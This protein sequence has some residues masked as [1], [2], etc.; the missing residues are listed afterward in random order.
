MSDR[1]PADLKAELERHLERWISRLG[2]RA[3]TEVIEIV[4]RRHRRPGRGRHPIDDELIVSEMCRLLC[5]DVTLS[6]W[7]IAA[8][9]ANGIT[10]EHRIPLSVQKRLWEKYKKAKKQFLAQ[11]SIDQM[12]PSE[13]TLLE[14]TVMIDTMPDCEQK[15]R[16]QPLRSLLSELLIHKYAIS[17]TADEIESDPPNFAALS[18]RNDV[19]V[20]EIHSIRAQIAQEIRRIK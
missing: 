17:E 16:L 11:F 18:K 20:R 19:L 10:D 3:V 1:Q 2:E 7:N 6:P 5:R 4:L 13:R 14:C 15:L 8:H 9:V 12:S